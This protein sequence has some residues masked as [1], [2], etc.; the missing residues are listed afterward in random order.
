M[1]PRL[2]FDPFTTIFTV[3]LLYT[4]M[5]L[6]VWTVLRGRHDTRITAL[7]C[8]GAAL[9]GATYLLWGLR[10]NLPS[11]LS[12]ELANAIGYVGYALR[13]AA[14]RLER[15]RVVPWRLLAGAVAA[16][17][18]LYAAA[19]LLGAERRIAYNLV[20]FAAASSLV[21]L[22]A[23]RLAREAA[24][25][26]A[27]MVSVTYWMLAGALLVRLVSLLAGVAGAAAGSLGLDVALVLITGLLAALWG[28][29]GYLGFAMENLQRR[30]SARMA[31]LAAAHAR[32]EQAERQAAELQQLSEE[33]QEL[34]RVIA[35]EV[36]QPLH[37]AQAVLQGV[38][39]AVRAEAAVGEAPRE[40]V[41]RARSVLRQIT[42]GLDNILAASTLLVGQR[43]TPLRDTDVDILLGLCLG[44]LPPAGRGRVR[45]VR[46][47]DVRTAA[48]DLGLMRLALRNLLN[49]A[50]A[51]SVPGSTVTLRVADSDDPLAVVFEVGDG[52]PGIAP[53]LLG[54]IFERGV[55]G[56]HD[57]PGQGL[58]LYIVRMAMRLQGGT[59]DVRS[60]P[61]GTVFTLSV[62]QGM[63]PA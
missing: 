52:G 10:P 37:N 7:W 59:V 57:L 5:P 19:G 32:R 1:V 34:L 12:F 36:R 8:S 15:E 63:E 31:D 20:A 29:V 27:R 18:A 60:G 51:Y 50:L 2:P 14:L 35:H 53:D 45:V 41:V 16:A 38:E 17:F 56:R 9:S 58:G 24:S 42:G 22:E 13:W 39:D 48:L 11:L 21:A 30:E 6:A 40:R 33:R 62:P 4:L 25:R 3:G 55:R 26:S 23:Q 44:D 47:A 43:P 46:D 49:N 61:E 28:N 54:R